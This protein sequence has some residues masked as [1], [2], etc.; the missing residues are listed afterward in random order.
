MH[1]V[2]A[3]LVNFV[4]A[5]SDWHTYV[6]SF[7]ILVLHI[8]SVIGFVCLCRKMTAHQDIEDEPMPAVEMEK[9]KHRPSIQ[10]VLSLV[11]A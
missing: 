11:D 7:I 5:L 10:T 2:F 6:P 4:L 8:P 1:N 3:L 9:K